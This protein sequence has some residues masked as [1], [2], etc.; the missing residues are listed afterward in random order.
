[1]YKFAYIPQLKIKNENE[2]KKVLLELLEDNHKKYH[3]NYDTF[4][5]NHIPHALCSLYQ[6]GASNQRLEEYYGN[7]VKKLVLIE[8]PNKKIDS[9]NYKEYLGKRNSYPAYLSFFDQILKEHGVGYCINTYL[10]D[11]IHGLTC[12]ALHPL[13]HIGYGI[14][15]DIP[16]IVTEGLAFLCD[17]YTS[18]AKILDHLA[19]NESTEKKPLKDILL[20][21]KDSHISCKKQ[22][23]VYL[24][25]LIKSLVDENKEEILKVIQKINIE[26]TER[27]IKELSLE[28]VKLYNGSF[29]KGKLDFFLLHLLTGNHA[30]RTIFTHLNE[31]NQKKLLLINYLAIIILYIVEGKPGYSQETIKNY[32][33]QSKDWSQIIDETIKSH[34]EHLIKGVRNLLQLKELYPETEEIMF[35]S[36]ALNTE[37]IKNHSDWNFSGIGLLSE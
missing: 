13:I 17:W 27:S 11:L 36:A 7:Y 1:M 4:K 26:G 14:E 20:T 33:P 25:D 23:G 24:D 5:A 8:T 21:I 34:D 22:K 2:S 18:T 19:T 28:T 16:I 37:N 3:I 9:Q 29:R 6:L 35:K 31:E 15:F 12:E 30:F 10:P 32:R